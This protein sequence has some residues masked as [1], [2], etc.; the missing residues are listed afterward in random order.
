MGPL[1]MA[2]VDT[3]AKVDASVSAWAKVDAGRTDDYCTLS[4]YNMGSWCDM[5]LWFLPELQM[6][7]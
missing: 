4:S 1:R 2:K 5:S 7:L 3:G 6:E